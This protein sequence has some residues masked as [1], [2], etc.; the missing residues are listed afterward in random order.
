MSSRPLPTLIIKGLIFLSAL[1]SRDIKMGFFPVPR[2]EGFKCVMY[3]P[4]HEIEHDNGRT[5]SQDCPL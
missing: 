3:V 5:T 2:Y 1:R 4:V